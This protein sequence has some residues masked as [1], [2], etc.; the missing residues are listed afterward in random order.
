DKNVEA[1]SH[2]MSRVEEA[3]RKE[4]DPYGPVYMM[5]QSG[6]AKG[7]FQQIRQIAGMRG[8]MAD[9]SGRIIELP[10]RSNFREG[11]S[12]LEYFIS[13][14]GARKGLADT[15]LRTA[16]S[17]YLTRRLIDVAQDVIIREEDCGTTQG[18]IIQR[19]GARAVGVNLT[20]RILGRNVAEDIVDPETGEIIV[21]FNEEIDEVAVERIEALKLPAVRVRSPLTCECR[22]GLC[23]KCYG[24]NLATA[25]PVE[26]GAAVGI[27]GAQSIGE[28]GTQLTMRTFHTGGVAGEDITQGLPRVEELFEARV[29]KGVAIISAIEGK[30]EIERGEPTKIRVVSVQAFTEELQLPDGFELVVDLDSEVAEGSIIARRSGAQVPEAGAED[31]RPTQEALA[32]LSEEDRFVAPVGGRLFEEGGKLLLRSEEREDA[33]YVIPAAARIR[34]EDGQMVAAGEQLTEGAV[35]PQDILQILGRE[36]VQEYLVDQVQ[37]VYRSQGVSINDKHI[38]VISRQMLRKVRVDT[39]GDTELLAGD[40]VD[41]FLYE[42]VNQRILAEG[43]EPATAQPVLLGVTKASLSTE[44][45]LAA[46]SFQETTRVLT[47]AASEGQKDRLLGLKENVIIGK[48]IPAGTGFLK[49]LERQRQQQLA[50]EAAEAVQDED[51][52]L[53][54]AARSLF[55]APAEP[56][57]ADS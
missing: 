31:G 4:L 57:G 25:Q 27:I 42:E 36:A 9:P 19:P 45:F 53:Q 54:A 43:G 30:V 29:P 22:Y 16:D 26:M 48:L 32:L 56:A 13:T 33:E 51:A 23:V 12:V 52:A 28:P 37:Q 21:R 7:G 50:A 55:G 8:L 2:A 15:A 24:R 47:Q 35:N 34:V 1:W 38:E 14:H 20:N 6:A 5:A 49:R 11:L 18:I 17:G 41:R 10:I 39:P 3:V 40:I 46:A 44:S